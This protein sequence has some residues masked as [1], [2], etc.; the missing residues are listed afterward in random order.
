MTLFVVSCE[1]KLG[2]PYEVMNLNSACRCSRWWGQ[3]FEETV[4]VLKVMRTIFWG[5]MGAGAQGDEDSILRKS[6]CWCS[7]WWG[8]YFEEK[9]VLVHKVMRTIFWG[10]VGVGAQGDGDNILRKSGCW[11][12]R[13]WGQYFDLKERKCW[14]A[15]WNCVMGAL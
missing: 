14:V 5:K 11:C 1:F 2:V 9:W 8:Q 4:L 13:W 12:S 10:K 3:Y 15:R 6:G 7:R